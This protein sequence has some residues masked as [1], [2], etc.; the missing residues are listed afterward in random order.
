MMIVSLRNLARALF[1]LALTTAGCSKDAP[2]P[3]APAKLELLALQ[4]R[5]L[6]NVNDG[7][8]VR[9]LVR[10]VEPKQFANDGYDSIVALAEHPDGSVLADQLLRPRSS[11]QLRLPLEVGVDVGVYFLFSR[12]AADSWKVLLPG[13]IGEATVVAQT[14]V[15]YSL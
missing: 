8:S 9:V 1:A 6:D 15:A 2:P 3:A 13:D 14:N 5:T 4:L 11:I 7:R 12:P 10:R